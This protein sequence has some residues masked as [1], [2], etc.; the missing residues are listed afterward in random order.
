MKTRRVECTM[1]TGVTERPV[2]DELCT[3]HGLMKPR[4]QRPCQRVPCDYTWQESSWSEVL[5]KPQSFHAVPL[6]HYLTF[7]LFSS[8]RFIAF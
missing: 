4:S 5:Q 3:R 8:S 2:D 7:L 6:Y 1:R